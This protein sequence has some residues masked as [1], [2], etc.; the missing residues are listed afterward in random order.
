MELREFNI[1][2]PGKGKVDVSLWLHFS[3]HDNSVSA[4]DIKI[5]SDFDSGL[6]RHPHLMLVDH[7]WKFHV[8]QPIMVEKEVVVE[9]KYSAEGLSKDIIRRIMDLVDDA[10]VK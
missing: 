9:D 5:H 7:E 6:P 3:D 4:Q 8:Q 2:V 10:K 1:D